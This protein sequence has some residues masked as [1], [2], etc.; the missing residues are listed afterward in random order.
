MNSCD[1]KNP[2]TTDTIRK[3]VSK[4]LS[5]DE[6]RRN[7]RK[8]RKSCDHEKIYIKNNFSMSAIF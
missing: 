5:D 8:R 6:E 2:S 3:K 1:V 4:V 7:F